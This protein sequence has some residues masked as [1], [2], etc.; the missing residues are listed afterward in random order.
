MKKLVDLQCYV[1]L[2]GEE[3]YPTSYNNHLRYVDED[4]VGQETEFVT[5][6]WETAVQCIEKHQVRNAEIGATL[7][8]NRPTLK[9][10]YGDIN[11]G[12]QEFTEKAFRSL[13]YKW[14][15]HE[16]KYIYSI[17]ELAKMLPADQFCEWIKDQGIFSVN[18]GG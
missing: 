12:W 2:N 16:V 9:I 17:N 15:A 11:K 18:I 6:D 4:A 7:W 14:I 13:K 3:Y 5:N 1:A 10:F 8:R